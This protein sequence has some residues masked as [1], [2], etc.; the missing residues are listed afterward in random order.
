[1]AALKQLFVVAERKNGE[2][3]R[4]SL[5]SAGAHCQTSVLAHGTARSDLLSVLGLDSSEKVLILATVRSR[6]VQLVMEMLKTNF[7]FGKG[8]GIAFTVPIT[9]VSSPAALLFLTG[10]NAR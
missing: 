6:K 8:G 3:I 9:A 4:A 1:M 10:G 5:T 2:K 7:D